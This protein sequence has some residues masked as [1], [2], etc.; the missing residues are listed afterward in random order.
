VLGGNAE[1]MAKTEMQRRLCGYADRPGHRLRLDQ[2][3]DILEA[4][5]TFASFAPASGK[6]RSRKRSRSK[7]P[8]AFSSSAPSATRPGVSTTS[9]GAAPGARRPRRNP[10]LPPLEDDLMRL[11]GGEK[12]QAVMNTLKVEEDTPSRRRSCPAASNR[13]NPRWK[14]AISHPPQPAAV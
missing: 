12:M 14:A 8:G 3:P 7:N 1:F 2:D 11:F 9:C 13:P 4:R 5:R 6:R 10:V